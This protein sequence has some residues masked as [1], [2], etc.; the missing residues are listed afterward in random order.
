MIFD[1]DV[2]K[3]L[4]FVGWDNP[5]SKGEPMRIMTSTLF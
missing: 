5:W 1:I 2:I 3:T 4:T